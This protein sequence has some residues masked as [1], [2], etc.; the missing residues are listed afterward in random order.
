MLPDDLENYLSEVKRVLKPNGK[1]L[2]SYYLLSSERP[3]EIVNSEIRNKFVNSAKGYWTTNLKYPED[4]TAYP[5]EY[6]LSLYK[7]FELKLTMPIVY[8][9]LQDIVVAT[10]PEKN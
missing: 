5:Q 3:Q 7:K 9:S 2:I 6:I 8:G 10:K 1:C 4:A